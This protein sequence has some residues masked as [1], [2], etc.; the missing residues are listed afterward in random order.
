MITTKFHEYNLSQFMLGT[1]QFGLNYGIAN[2]V[3]KPSYESVVRIIEHAAASGVTCLDTAAAYGDSEKVIGCALRELELADKMTVITKMPHLADNLES[4]EADKA[5]REAIECSLKNL[6]LDSIA[7]YLFHKESNAA[8][9]DSVRKMQCKGLVK[10][11]GISVNSPA[12]ALKAIRSGNYEAIQLPTNILDHRYI[13]A[14]VFKEAAMAGVAVFV[15]SVYLQGLLFLPEEKILPEHRPVIEVRRRL[16]QIARESK[17]TLTELAARFVMSLDG[18]CCLVMGLETMTQLRDNLR[19]F[20]QGP[21]TSEQ[22][23]HI[24]RAVPFL[25]DV[26]IMPWLWPKAFHA[27]MQ[28]K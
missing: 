23:E 28:G 16:E 24:M 2:Q 1:V 4:A 6:Q 18:V 12:W 17:M 19:L 22:M 25:P 26:V 15:R 21:L 20:E 14:G 5:V 9:I 3:G 7:L 27:K 10:Y 13:H 11:I 8:Y